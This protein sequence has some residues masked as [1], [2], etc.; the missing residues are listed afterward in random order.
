MRNHSWTKKK[1]TKPAWGI[2]NPKKYRK[3]LQTKR[4]AK[5]RMAK[6]QTK[7]DVREKHIM[8]L[9]AQLYGTLGFEELKP[10]IV[11]EFFEVFRTLE[12]EQHAKTK[13]YK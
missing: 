3:L 10:H 11:L 9:R 8:T 1:K 6:E 12:A 7:D 2:K 5:V 13:S 4:N